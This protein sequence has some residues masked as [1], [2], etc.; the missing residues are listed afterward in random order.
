M[1]QVRSDFAE[2]IKKQGYKYAFEERDSLTEVPPA[3]FKEQELNLAWEQWTAVVE[4]DEPEEKTTELSDAPVSDT[5]EGFTVYLKARTFHRRKIWSK[6]A[7]RP[8]PRLQNLAAQSVPHS[9]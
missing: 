4:E 5:V 2:G 9:P 3:L 8:H 7:V 1:A 6:E